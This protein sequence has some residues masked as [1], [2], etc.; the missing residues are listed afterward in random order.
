MLV[1]P[2]VP[3]FR[4]TCRFDAAEIFAVAAA[5][6]IARTPEPKALMIGNRFWQAESRPEEI[7]R[8]RLTVTVREN[9]RPRLFFR[10]ERFINS[11][12]FPRHCF[13]TELVRKILRQ[14]TGRLILGFRRFKA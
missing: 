2:R 3:M 7:D 11:R 9:C 13:P 4:A 5:V 6:V 12:G 14:R 10:R 8:A 1:A